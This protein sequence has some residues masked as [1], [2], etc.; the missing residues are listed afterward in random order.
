M[1]RAILAA[2]IFF[3]AP[4]C[5]FAQRNHA[6]DSAAAPANADATVQLLKKL[7]NAPGPSGFEE[8][9]AK[10]MVDEMQPYAN[11]ISYDGL[12]SVIATQGSSGPR[13]MLDA[14]M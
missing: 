7:V 8:P 12:G 5:A 9:V 3:V 1:R 4:V 2:L 6:P 10:I 11:K 13:I 14:H